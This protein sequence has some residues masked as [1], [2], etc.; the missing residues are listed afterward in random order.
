M[1]WCADGEFLAISGG[2]VCKTLAQS[3]YPQLI[4]THKYIW[5][6]S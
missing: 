4:F 6:C 2:P 1:R 3:I 5:L